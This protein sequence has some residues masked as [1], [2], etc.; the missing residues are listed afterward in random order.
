MHRGIV[1]TRVAACSR[2]NNILLPFWSSLWPLHGQGFEDLITAKISQ[3]TASIPLVMGI[4]PE[5][6]QHALNIMLERSCEQQ[7]HRKAA[8]YHA[9]LNRFK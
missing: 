5:L 7:L 8:Y 6:W 4:H 2:G 1:L 9:F 3:L